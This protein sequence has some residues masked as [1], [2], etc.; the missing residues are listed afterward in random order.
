MKFKVGDMVVSPY[1]AVYEVIT[2]DGDPDYYTVMSVKT[3]YK[4]IMNLERYELI[5]K[6]QTTE[7]THL[8]FK[9]GDVVVSPIGTKY[10]VT[11]VLKSGLYGVYAVETEH[12][13]TVDLKGY[14]LY[15]EEPTPRVPPVL[16]ERCR[17]ATPQRLDIEPVY[18]RVYAN[19]DGCT[20]S[21]VQKESSNALVVKRAQTLTRD[22]PPCNITDQP[23]NI[24][25]VSVADKDRQ[26]AEAFLQCMECKA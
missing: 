5:Y 19:G 20:S 24:I 18:Y 12:Y 17:W 10:E 3:K 22:I 15:L 23:V 7:N 2:R 9:I 14:K 21:G 6:D 8:A 1:G 13:Y 4:H 11:S 16:L 26:R 25:G